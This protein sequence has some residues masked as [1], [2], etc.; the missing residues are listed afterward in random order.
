[1]EGHDVATD[2][3]ITPWEAALGAKVDVPTL[4]GPAVVTVPAGTQS[5]Q[6]LR[7]KGKG[8]PISKGKRGDE[9]A[10]IKIVVPKKL[11]PKERELFEELAKTSKF[12]P[13][14]S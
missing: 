5:G 8:L 11:N 9:Y 2:L 3:Q 14:T 1:M 12:N 10:V 7:L 13:R 4:E 6:R